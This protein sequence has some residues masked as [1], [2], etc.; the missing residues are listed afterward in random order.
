MVHLFRTSP[1]YYEAVET[2]IDLS[3]IKQKLKSEEY[4]EVEQFNEDI[5]LLVNNSK[6]FYKV[7]RPQT[8]KSVPCT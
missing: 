1:E 4:E 5:E 8:V 6:L 7:I 2:P 3:K